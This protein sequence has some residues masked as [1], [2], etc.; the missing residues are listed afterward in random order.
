MPNSPEERSDLTPV[1]KYYRKKALNYDADYE[2]LYWKMYNDLTWHF[3]QPYLPKRKGS[4]I[5]D[6]GGGTGKWAIKLAKLGYSVDFVEISPEMLEIAQRKF[7]KEEVSHKITIY[8]GDIRDLSS[9][10]PNSYDLVLVLGDVISYALDDEISIKEMYRI[11][12]TGG[13]GIASVDSKFVYLLNHIKNNQFSAVEELERSNI[14]HF[15]KSH[16]LKTYTPVQLRD[17]FQ[18]CGY[19]VIKLYGKGIFIGALPRKQRE[20]KL[21]E[22]YQDFF[23]LETKYGQNSSF[24]G[25][26]GHIQITVQK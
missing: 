9:F 25:Q 12:A 3:L 2:D 24:I 13:I 21:K 8:T 19:K 10:L 17:L 5:I 20:K 14:T 15:F 22:H 23:E 7:E 6:L 1:I 11:T 4:R 26:A 18:S 16:P